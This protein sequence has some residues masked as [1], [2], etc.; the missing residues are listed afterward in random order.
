MTNITDKSQQNVI[1]QLVEVWRVLESLTVSLDRLGMY[2]L[3]VGERRAQ[4]ALDR[5]M[6]PAMFQRIANAR[7]IL[8]TLIEELDE[9][10]AE[11][12]ERLAEEDDG[13]G[14][15]SRET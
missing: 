1:P 15:W 10:M 6:N 5:Y 2:Q 13:I 11:E 3:H 12:L 7:R 4:E 14:Y 9:T 8:V